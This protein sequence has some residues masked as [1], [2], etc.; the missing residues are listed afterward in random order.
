MA[1]F[2]RICGDRARSFGAISASISR[3][4]KLPVDQ[5][6][7]VR[8]VFSSQVEAGTS[9]RHLRPYALYDSGRAPMPS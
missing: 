2:E 5:Q 9:K 8:H 6:G 1:R 7:V 3:L 4:N